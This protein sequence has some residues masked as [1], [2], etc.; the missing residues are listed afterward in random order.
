MPRTAKKSKNID[1]KHP[2]YPNDT[3]QEA[4][5]EFRFQALPEQSWSLKT[6]GEL[7]KHLSKK[8]PGME[9]LKEMEV[10]LGIDN[11]T[12]QTIQRIV[13]SGT[14]LRFSN[15]AGTR[16]VQASPSMFCFNAVK[17][18][19][20]WETMR[21][22]I[23]SNWEI[24]SNTLNNPEINRIGLRYIN[25][26]PLSENHPNLRDWLKPNEYV[27]QGI[28]KSESGFSYR[29]ESKLS[30]EN[31][32]I[33]TIA[34]QKDKDN[35]AYIFFDVDCVFLA[36]E[37]NIDNLPS[38]LKILHD[39]AWTIFDSAKTAVLEKYLNTERE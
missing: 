26:I 25:R 36:S 23:L 34:N 9:P 13:E 18:Y 37:R 39:E 7:F 17:E 29:L 27:P 11:K 31:L 8:F 15:D 20:G 10:Q 19:P 4:L 32:I 14:K 2:S 24:V 35:N 12:G 22:E 1:Q 16:L 33:V 6:P 3:I 5:C 38:E 21:E 28:I 30:S